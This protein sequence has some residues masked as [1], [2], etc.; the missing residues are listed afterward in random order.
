MLDPSARRPSLSARGG[1][2]YAESSAQE[3]PDLFH[4]VRLISRRG[5]M[6]RLDRVPDSCASGAARSK[7]HPEFISNFRV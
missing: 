6:M 2:G 7:K 1:L 5:V 4:E 3:S